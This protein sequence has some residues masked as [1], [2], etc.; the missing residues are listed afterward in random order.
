[1]LF[2]SLSFFFFFALLLGLHYA[3][4]PWRVKKINLLVASYIF[5]A[6]WNP[7]FVVLLWL[8]TVVDWYMTKKISQTEQH[9]RR[10]L[11]LLV[12]VV[13][14]LGLLGYFKYGKFLLDNFT[15]LVQAAG[16]DYHPAAPDI[17]LPVG[18][19]FY[20]FQTMAYT[21]DVYLRRAKPANNFLD[22]AL[23]VTFFPQLV[24]GP[25]VRPTELVPQFDQ[26]KQA[27]RQQ[28]F[29]GLG[30]LTLGLFQ[31][32]VVADTFLSGTSEM[33]FASEQ[34][35]HGLDAW[36]GVLAFSGQIFCDFAGYSTAAI[37]IA[38]CLGFALPENFHCPYGSVG[39]SDFWR[40]WHITLSTWL[41]D[42]L[43]IPLGGNRLGKARTYLNL[44]I[45]MVLGGLWHGANWTFV[46]W[47]ALHGFYLSAE[48]VVRGWWGQKPWVTFPAVQV[49]L[50]IGTFYLIVISWVFFRATTFASAG[51]LLASMHG[52]H[53]DGAQIV[54]M[55]K[56]LLVAGTMTAMFFLHWGLRRVTLEEAVN[57]SPAWLVGTV[58]AVMVFFLI[59]NQGGGN[60][61]IYFQF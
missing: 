48:R 27:N 24:A 30:L 32:M 25:I 41:R 12:S 20:T 11:F 51:M 28:M 43:Y 3:P 50:A 9:A 21:L 13:L 55:T 58:W 19:S 53:P 38:L 39:F 5:Y 8:S 35:L 52:W 26:P 59:I 57:R 14:N 60:A 45:T 4:L 17:I 31:K 10:R 42:Y 7:P 49:L 34:P 56:I 1:M 6:A 16:W 22:F 23:F 37:G 44:M 2:N 29:W 54:P 33:V 15:A 18:I 46:A 36:L 40:R 61:F 47:G